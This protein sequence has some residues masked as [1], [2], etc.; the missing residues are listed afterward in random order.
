MLTISL[1]LTHI[2][3]PVSQLLLAMGA[4]HAFQQMALLEGR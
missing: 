4:K 2:D 3:G 1:L